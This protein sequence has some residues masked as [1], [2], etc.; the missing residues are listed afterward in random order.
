MFFIIVSVCIGSIDEENLLQNLTMYYNRS[1]RPVLN[2][3]FPL[4][5]FVGLSI[6]QII[7]VV[8][9]KIELFIYL[10]YYF[11]L[12]FLSFFFPSVLFVFLTFTSF[13]FLFILLPLF[14][15]FSILLGICLFLLFLLPCFLL[16]VLFLPFILAFSF[17]LGFF[18][19]SFKHDCRLTK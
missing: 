1:V 5:V 10:C 11:C 13:F 12:V 2:D 3:S 19:H 9:N 4:K 18:F 16:W 7:D 15:L 8:S 6:S 17:C 14:F